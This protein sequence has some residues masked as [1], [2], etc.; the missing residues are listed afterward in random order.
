MKHVIGTGSQVEDETQ[1]LAE[2]KPDQEVRAKTEGSRSGQG[3]VGASGATEDGN[4]KYGRANLTGC[5]KFLQSA[6]RLSGMTT[7]QAAALE[8]V[9]SW[10]IL[11]VV[12]KWWWPL[13]LA[14]EW[15]VADP[16]RDLLLEFERFLPGCSSKEVTG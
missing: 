7:P 6:N 3:L 9:G 16:F 1:N 11:C 13:K 8:A 10:I 4:W 2:E 5:P 12:W 15:R 14:K